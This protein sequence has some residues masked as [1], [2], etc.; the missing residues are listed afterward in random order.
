MLPRWGVPSSVTFYTFITRSYY[1]IP[2][3]RIVDCMFPLTSGL[4][5][6][7][8]TL[9]L[10]LAFWENMVQNCDAEIANRGGW[11]EYCARLHTKRAERFGIKVQIGKFGICTRISK[12]RKASWILVPRS[13]ELRRRAFPARLSFSKPLSPSIVREELLF[14]K[15]IF[16]FSNFWKDCKARETTKEEE[17]GRIFDLEHGKKQFSY[18][19]LWI[20]WHSILQT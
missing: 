9:T 4:H 15:C 17:E 12:K 18:H 6:L 14:E 10:E 5:A 19:R 2:P 1:L 8:G 3:F 13:L 11:H 16:R 7:I 20:L